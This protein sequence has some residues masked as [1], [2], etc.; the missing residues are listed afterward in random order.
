[1]R[2]GQVRGGGM[3]RAEEGG[4]AMWSRGT[5]VSEGNKQSKG[6]SPCVSVCLSLSLPCPFLSPK[7]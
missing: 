6:M 7:P 1:M 2:G 3:W 5:V 4:G